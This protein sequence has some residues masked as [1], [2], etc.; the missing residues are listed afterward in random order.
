MTTDNQATKTIQ[1]DA[2]MNPVEEQTNEKYSTWKPVV[3]G[4]VSG[5][6]MGAGA[7]YAMNAMAGSHESVD[8]ANALKVADSHDDLSFGDA[9]TEAR[10]QVGAGGVFRWHGR[11]YNTYT[12]EEWD[13]MDADQKEVFAHQVKPEIGPNDV[14]A[15]YVAEHHKPA[16]VHQA[17]AEDTDAPAEAAVESSET[18]SHS[19]QYYGQTNNHQ[20]T[21]DDDVQLVSTGK[22]DMGNGYYADAAKYRMDGE[23]VV[24]I[25]V[26]N[27]D[28]W[29]I[30][31][32]DINHDNHITDNEVLNLHTGE[33]YA[34]HTAQQDV[35]VYTTSDEQT[36]ETTDQ[37]FQEADDVQDVDTSDCA[38]IDGLDTALI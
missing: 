30:A 17:V 3:I 33:T 16:N 25:D 21:N 11:I 24:V 34:Q 18:A 6:L 36:A 7:L 12:R 9:F 20:S 5:I 13:A 15:N 27:D 10:S 38:D 35:P 26:D 29:D 14:N 19:Q 1:S 2:V 8:N 4:G 28:Q 37:G 22:I 31:I 23:D 32:A